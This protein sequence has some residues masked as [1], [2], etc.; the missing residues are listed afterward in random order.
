MAASRS[1]LSGPEAVASTTAPAPRAGIGRSFA[2]A[3]IFESPVFGLLAMAVA[4]LGLVAWA[5]LASV[6]K[7]VRVEGRIIPAGHSQTI[8]HLEGG[9]VAAIAVREG[10]NVARG[11][12]LVVIDDTSAEANLAE[13][14]TKLAAQMIRAARLS[15]EA[16]GADSVS[17]PEEYRAFPALAEAELQLFRARRGKMEAERQ[18]Y[19]EQAAQRAAEIREVASR[20]QRLGGELVTAR[21]RLDLVEAMAAKSAAS[22]LEV[23][24]AQSREQRLGTELASAESSL[25]K[26]QAAMSELQAR[27]AESRARLKAEAQGELAT[28]LIEINRLRQ[29]LTTEADRYRR[30]E[31]RAPVDGVVNR[32]NVTTVG[33]VV[34][35]GDTIV[36]LTPVTD[37]LLIEAK[38]HPSDRAELRTGLPA[39]LRIGAYDVGEFGVLKG[40]VQEVSA[41]TVVDPRGEAY[42]RVAIRVDHLPES[43]QGRQIVP[44]MTVNGDVI[45]GQRT[46]LKYLTSPF[47]KFTYNAFRDAR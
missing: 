34:K 46:V 4:V 43:Y 45:I 11:E 23:L 10:Q 25:P 37:T 8:Q 22:S 40:S 6:D 26:L 32:V 27:I 41:D 7:V 1:V 5:A 2:A 16:N 44:G 47:T 36:E 31:V 20:R 28:V 39:K 30:T 17:V 18:V 13:T 15:A 21:K 42:Y 35:P 12:V 33:G 38:A 14:R 9:I 3:R 24:E 29:L 19:E